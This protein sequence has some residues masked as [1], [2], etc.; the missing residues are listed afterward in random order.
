MLYLYGNCERWNIKGEFRDLPG[1]H[2]VI[3]RADGRRVGPSR[4]VKHNLL[5]RGAGPPEHGVVVAVMEVAPEAGVRGGDVIT[6]D[7]G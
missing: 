7:Q 1:E 3:L 2:V 4:P 5:V 6:S